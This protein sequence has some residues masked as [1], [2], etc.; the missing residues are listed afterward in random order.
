ML[1]CQAVHLLHWLT[2]ASGFVECLFFSA[3]LFG[4]AS[5][6]YVLKMEGYFSNFCVN[7]T[8]A[9]SSM[10]TDCSGQ[11]EQFSLI[12]TVGC[13]AANFLTLPN[14]FILDRFGTMAVR[15]LAISLYTTGTLLMA[16][17][18]AD[19]SILVYPAML[20]ISGGGVSLFI[21]NMQVGNLFSS[22][23]STIIT[24]YTGA[25]N[26][27]AIVFLIIKVLYERGVS[28]R[29][30]FLFMSA[31]S[32]IHLLRTFLLMPKTHI[33]CPLPED[34]TYGL[35]SCGQSKRPEQQGA[36]RTGTNGNVLREER[37][38]SA[39]SQPE[40]SQQSPDPAVNETSFRSCV[41]SWFFAWHLLWLSV[42]QLRQY[43]YVGTLNPTLNRLTEGDPTLV[44][45]YT[46]AFSFTQMCGV[47]CAPWNGLIMDRNKGKPLAPGETE[48]EADLRSSAL[49]L[50]LT[51]LL[52]LLFNICAAIPFLPL[53]YLTFVLQILNR[54]FL[55]G[56]NYAFISIAFPSCHYGK[57]C[58]LTLLMAS[59]VLL[60]QFPI[61]FLVNDVLQGNPLYVDIALTLLSL[62][63]FIH[64]LYIYLHC[65]RLAARRR[66]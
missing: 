32:I 38:E 14:G 36:V 42:M 9:N 58:A 3:F 31:C 63:A 48:K 22:R 34:Y 52:C 18:R 29:S 33:P 37:L 39:P 45:S 61:L 54:C 6:V 53:Q 57:L 1:G 17:S 20:C 46:N 55:Y 25:Y 4:W 27:T 15:I 49:S 2:L 66:G 5:L 50:F 30:S 44:S 8:A 35:S 43:F 24:L 11:D 60:L 7:S 26:S 40:D 64:P 65:R 41:L 10:Y 21:T 12:F 56:G 28:L 62:L 23:R 59:V 19:F 47:F 13:L 16:F 51:A